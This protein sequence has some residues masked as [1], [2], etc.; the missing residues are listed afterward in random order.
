MSNNNIRITSATRDDQAFSDTN[1]YDLLVYTE[2][3]GQSVLLGNGNDPS[4]PSSLALKNDKVFI[5]RNVDIQGNTTLL[6]DVT[7]PG[8]FRIDNGLSVSGYSSF[9]DGT[10]EIR[11]VQQNDG[12]ADMLLFDVDNTRQSNNKAVVVAY[13]ATR[14]ECNLSVK[15]DLVVEGNLDVRGIVGSDNISFGS[16][17][18][19]EGDLGVGSS[20][21]VDGALTSSSNTGKTSVFTDLDVVDGN[22]VVSRGTANFRGGRMIVTDGLGSDD[23]MTVDTNNVKI[24][25]DLHLTD[26]ARLDGDVNIGHVLTVNGSAEFESNLRVTG[27]TDLRGTLKVLP[28]PGSSVSEPAMVVNETCVEL[29]RD[30]SVSSNLRVL[31]GDVVIETG[32]V[33][34]MN[35]RFS[36]ND[37]VTSEVRIGVDASVDSNL[38]VKGSLVTGDDFVAAGGAARFSGYDIA[39]RR[40]FTAHCNIETKNDVDVGSNLSVGGDLKVRGDVTLLDMGDLEV[41]GGDFR[42][43]P[44]SVNACNVTALEVTDQIVRASRYF[45]A[46]SNAR[47]TGRLDVDGG[48]DIWN[49]LVVSS[50]DMV[51]A[52][53]SMMAGDTGVFL[54]RDVLVRSNFSVD[55]GDADITGGSLTVRPDGINL[56]FTVNGTRVTCHESLAVLEGINVSG[57]DSVMTGGTF[58]VNPSGVNGFEVFTASSGRVDIERGTTVNGVTSIND[59][60]TVSTGGGG[61]GS[62]VPALRVR[63]TVVGVDRNANF[64]CN[65]VM[66]GDVDVRG[67]VMT[68][69]SVIGNGDVLSVNDEDVQINRPLIVSRDATVEQDSTVKGVF[70]VDPSTTGSLAFRVTDTRMEAMV[71]ARITGELDVRGPTVFQNGPVSMRPAGTDGPEVLSVTDSRLKLTRDLLQEAPIAEFVGDRFSVVNVDSSTQNRSEAAVITALLARF[72]RDVLLSCNIDVTGRISTKGTLSVAGDTSIDGDLS[73]N[74]NL[75]VE[76]GA[77][78]RGD[79]NTEGDL[80]IYR[81]PPK[82]IFAN[83]NQLIASITPSRTTINTSDTRVNCPLSVF[84]SGPTTTTGAPSVL[85]DTNRVDVNEPLYIKGDMDVRGDLRVGD[86][87][88]ANVDYLVA[89]DAEVRVNRPF[90]AACNLEVNADLKVHFTANFSDRVTV[91]GGGLEVSGGDTLLNCNLQVGKNVS[92]E[93][94]LDVRGST[95]VGG[96]SFRVSEPG[97]GALLDV[98]DSDLL[99]HRDCVAY[100]NLDV[101]GVVRVG[102]STSASRVLEITPSAIRADTDELDLT[103]D[104]VSVQTGTLEVKSQPSDQTS[105]I[106][107]DASFEIRRNA[108]LGSNL[109]VG[110]DVNVGGNTRI[111]SD[112]F[113]VG[114]VDPASASLVIDGGNPTRINRDLAVASNLDIIGNLTALGSTRLDGSVTIE[115]SLE[116]LSNLV[117]RSNTDMYGPLDIEINGANA[118]QVRHEGITLLRDAEAKSNVTVRGYLA[119]DSNVFINDDLTVRPAGNNG[120]EVMRVTATD[121]LMQADLGVNGDLSLSRDAQINRDLE[122]SRNANVLQVLTTSNLKVTGEA[123]ARGPVNISDRLTVNPGNGTDVLVVGSNSV[124]VMRDLM[125]TGDV[126]IVAGELEVSAGGSRSMLVGENE[127]RI[128]RDLI[129]TGDVGLDHDLY[130][131]NDAEIRQMLTVRGGT[132]VDGTLSVGD[133][134]VMSSNLTVIGPARMS[135]DFEVFTGGSLGITDPSFNVDSSNV[136]TRLN[137]RVFA[138]MYVEGDLT[139]DSNIDLRGDLEMRHLLLAE[140]APG[141]LSLGFT[142]TPSTGF[143]LT[144]GSNNLA[145]SVNGAR[146]NVFTESGIETGIA[147]ADEFYGDGCNITGL[148]VDNV[149]SGIL[150]I[151]RGGTGTGTF[152]EDRIVV[153]NG[154][155]GLLTASHLYWDFEAERLGVGVFPPTG[156]EAK[157]HVS[158]DVLASG[159]RASSDG[160]P[161]NLAFSFDAS[162]LQTGFFRNSEGEIEVSVDGIR[163]TRLVSSGVNTNMMRATTL[164]GDGSNVTNLNADNMTLGVLNVDRGGTGTPSHA[165]SKVL[166]GN[167]SGPLLSPTN[168][169]WDVSQSRLGVNV[170]TPNHVLHV[171]GEAR[172]TEFLGGGAGLTGLN[173]NNAGSG[174]LSVTRGGTGRGAHDASKIMVGNGTDSVLNPVDLHWDTSNR[175]MGIRTASPGHELEVNG[176]VSCTAV[177]GEGSGI[178]NLDMNN[179]GLGVLDVERGGTGREVHTDGKLLV[180]NGTDGVESPGDLHWTGSRLGVGTDQPEQLLHVDGVCKADFFEGDGNDVSNLDMDKAGTGVLEVDRGGTGAS[181]HAEFKLMVGN[182]QDPVFTPAQLHW[183]PTTCNL[184]IDVGDSPQDMLHVRERVRAGAFVGD[185]NNVTNLNMENAGTGLLSVNRGGTGAGTHANNKLVVGNGASPLQTPTDLHWDGVNLGIGTSNPDKLL[186]VDGHTKTNALTVVGNAT[187]GALIGD[188]SQITNLSLNNT[189]GGATPLS[190]TNG[191]TGKKTLTNDRLLVGS[192][193]SA[194]RTPGDLTYTNGN[195][196]L[197]T[198]SPSSKLQVSGNIDST[199]FSGVGSSIRDLDADN[200]TIGILNVNRGGTGQGILPANK[201][202]IGNGTS[203]VSSSEIYWT[204]SRM[205]VGTAT[206]QYLLDVDGS[207][208]VSANLN[209]GDV[210]RANFFEGDGR[211]LSNLTVQNVSAGMLD[212]EFGG[213]GR[214][215]LDDTKVLVG[216]GSRGVESAAGLVWSSGNLGINTDGPASALDVVGTT[217]TTDCFVEDVCRASF[218]EGDGRRL[219]NLNVDNVSNGILEVQYG[220]TGRSNL[221]D[222]RVLVGNGTASLESATNLYWTGSGLGVNLDNPTS[223]L[224]VAGTV[225]STNSIAYDVS[226]ASFFEGDGRRL[227]N[228]NVNN[229]SNGTLDVQYGGTGR[230]SLEDSKLLVGNGTAGVESASQLYWT[231]SNM[232]LFVDR[233]SD[234]FQVSGTMRTTD[235]IVDD[236]AQASFFEGDGSRLSNITMENVSSGILEVEFGGTGRSNLDDSRVLVGKGTSGLESAGELYYRNENGNFG[237]GEAFPSYRLQVDGDIRASGDIVAD[238]DARI[239]TNLRPIRDAYAKIDKLRGYVYDRVDGSF[240]I[241]NTEETNDERDNGS[242]YMGFIAQEVAK[243]VPEVIHYDKNKDTYGVAYGNLVALLAEGLKEVHASF[244]ARLERLEQELSMI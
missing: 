208:R 241:R 112:V 49:G 120:P 93:G 55:G 21:T 4:R 231:G 193:T 107:T 103:A 31:N 165:S 29:R 229:V 91:Q 41:I 1:K 157:L 36:T 135:N 202:V 161:T 14:V 87:T 27:A 212:V 62:S 105:L 28:D 219:S 185:G 205:G 242:S 60:F 44:R 168:L 48:T 9:R 70:R 187:A 84:A 92:T 10:F 230:S 61:G 52:S 16:N 234:A 177:R 129:C 78:L 137:T 227:S 90:V 24:T 76:G 140:G 123:N 239:K 65:V 240:R 32:D 147:R 95:F 17:V 204:G 13:R 122:V 150:D 235:M 134:A 25:Q 75:R 124:Q 96:G 167:G 119:V 224:E 189:G 12:G 182:A 113:T 170:A 47:V 139:V 236:V 200:V 15:D 158:G 181:N 148:N 116:T 104:D 225:K 133:D 30:V 143:F 153:G 197:G 69:E 11:S 196:G 194:V 138:D 149:A 190:V 42:A 38:R 191:G 83:S 176:T 35:G 5:N 109:R 213:T 88:A 174:I 130:V 159:F 82:S 110:G 74:S 68:V 115:G 175:R 46:D 20:F 180:G 151:Q 216:N 108:V 111:E 45:L 166:V 222:M 145:F 118:L 144:P 40:A 141:D 171:V 54:N 57:G 18:R 223:A 50:G 195:L 58:V 199:T 178:T 23:I 238:S 160:S 217:K 136:N 207:A 164:I 39:F 210:S 56:M 173:M 98:R 19:V 131:G 102:S 184:G 172:A 71:N 154:T 221:D 63:D 162:E 99:F 220:G 79:V 169:H 211:R 128:N 163:D 53:N 72:D 152:A 214:S 22:L 7:M 192:G 146:S 237:V 127:T 203:G 155:S 215:N 43:A 186:T 156:V 73:V 37:P 228:L 89:E 142:R 209:V 94:D 26:D 106:L 114:S 100:S 179:S 8:G 97:V 244:G 233:P 66:R 81:S 183:N 218:F 80:V 3:S 206:P 34:L 188:G 67:G 64:S 243:V 6:G 125:V 2:S 126:R 232:G 59:D 51:T 101:R 85:V 117:V 33:R 132:R 198:S 201:A 77:T 121:V 86:H 226:K